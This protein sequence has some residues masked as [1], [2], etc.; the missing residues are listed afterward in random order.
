MGVNLVVSHRMAK[1]RQMRW[2]DER[3]HCLVQVRVA[4]LNGE[5]SP[6]NLGVFGVRSTSASDLRKPRANDRSFQQHGQP[7]HLPTF[8]RLSWAGR[9]QS[10]Q[11]HAILHWPVDLRR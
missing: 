11:P 5:L 10:D 9:Y 6:A 1:Y 3:A 4:V 7:T 8:C 2:T